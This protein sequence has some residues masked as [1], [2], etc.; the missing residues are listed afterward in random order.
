MKNYKSVV[1]LLSAI[2]TSYFFYSIYK[3]YKKNSEK[4]EQVIKLLKEIKCSTNKSVLFPKLRIPEDKSELKDLF[5]FPNK[6]LNPIILIPDFGESKLYFKWKTEDKKYLYKPIEKNW[7]KL[8]L[9]MC[10][11]SPNIPGANNWKENMSITYDSKSEEKFLDNE[12]INVTSWRKLNYNK[13][14]KFRCTKDFGYLEGVDKLFTISGSQNY[15]AYIFHT[16]INFFKKKGYKDGINI[17][18]TSYDFRKIT[19]PSLYGYLFQNV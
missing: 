13:N 12:N 11:L 1:L 4:K 18:G 19:S 7:E 9:S 14:G 3:I 6:K 5:L 17:F 8:W 16:L 10:A 2:G 15:E